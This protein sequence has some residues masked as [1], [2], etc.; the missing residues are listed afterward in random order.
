MPNRILKDSIRESVSINALSPE[1]EVC[2][3]RLITYADDY[4]L[5]RADLCLANSFLFPRKHFKDTQIEKW[6]DEIA[7][8]DMIFFY[9]VAENLYG[10]FTNWKKHKQVRA[11]RSK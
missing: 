4:G 9:R 1:A 8:A 2:F 10:A 6:L 5:F 11:Q 7:K 3:Y